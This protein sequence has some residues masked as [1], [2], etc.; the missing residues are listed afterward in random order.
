MDEAST[1]QN[2]VQDGGRK[3]FVMQ[4]LT[5]FAE[6]FVGSEDHGSLS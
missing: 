5:P 1:L 4:D 3:I 6:G 2:S